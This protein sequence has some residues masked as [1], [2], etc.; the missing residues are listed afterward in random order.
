VNLVHDTICRRARAAVAHTVH[1]ADGVLTRLVR[2]ER[3][4]LFEAASPLSLAVF[5]PVLAQL[6]RDPRIEFWF[7]TSDRWWDAEHTFSA[8][9][10]AD[11]VI[12]PRQARWMKFDGYVNTD[13][14]NTTW[15]SR[16]TT[17]IH[18]FHGVAGKYGLD[19]PVR[20]A[21]VVRSFNR[22]MF[23]NADRLRRYVDAGLVEP[24]GPRAQLI[25]FPKADCL[26]DGTFNRR[27]IQ[28]ALG[29]DSS[30]PTVLY[31]P[32]WSAHSSLNSIGADLLPALAGLDVNVI[33][34]LHDRSFDERSRTE[35]SIDWKHQLD[36]LCRS[37]KVHAARD[38]DISRYLY[39]SDV[40]V[41]DHSSAGFE[42]MLLDRPIVVID[43]PQLIRHARV[44]SD[45]VE[46][47]R[48][49]AIVVKRHSAAAITQAVRRALADPSAASAERRAAAA[50]MFYRPGTATA[51][52]VQC[53]Y[54]ALNLRAFA[55]EGASTPIIPS[56]TVLSSSRTAHHV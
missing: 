43:C 44:A 13:F 32:T 26:V 30:L 18:L 48:D 7:T 51:R 12:T 38:G 1:T 37:W 23:A 9:G 24:E 35:G 40:L 8:S 50:R 53:I 56:P 27:E 11:R 5:R 45:K 31:A 22:V 49:A 17:R 21:P 47:L 15:L 46:L 14:W 10:I 2:R 42:F 41:T 33:V 55:A 28:D 34:K 19:A 54:D 29:L 25:G 6:Q 36:A 16:R 4:V 20:I 52:A 3:R 39:V